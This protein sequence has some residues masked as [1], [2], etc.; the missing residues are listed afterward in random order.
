M[1]SD[2]K[3][4]LLG[5]G[6]VGFVRQEGVGGAGIP[7]RFSS[8][9]NPGFR[10]AVSVTRRWTEA[11]RAGEAAMSAAKQRAGGGR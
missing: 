3:M 6:V 10:G 9:A 2:Y 1:R 8:Q 5:F 4:L 7:D 11:R